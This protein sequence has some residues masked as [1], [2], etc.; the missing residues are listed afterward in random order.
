MNES[1]K[2]IN[3]GVKEYD[4]VEWQRQNEVVGSILNAIN[5][6]EDYFNKVGWN[7]E[8]SLARTKLQEADM[9]LGS[10]NWEEITP[11]QAPLPE[12]DKGLDARICAFCLHHEDDTEKGM[13]RCFMCGN[14]KYFEPN[15]KFSNPYLQGKVGVQ[16]DD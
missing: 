5:K 9:W 8:A 10:V 13:G 14:H 4:D 2:G 3:D 7:R 6:L 15:P 11:N 1:E 12:G 16:K